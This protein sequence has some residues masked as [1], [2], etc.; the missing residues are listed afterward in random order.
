VIVLAVPSRVFGE[1]VR[2]LPGNAPVVT[3]TKGL[4]PDT[5]GRLCTLVQER[6]V[7]VLSRPN[8][9]EEIAAGLPTASVIASED[10]ELAEPLQA[11]INS[12]TFRVFV[13]PDLLGVELCAATK[14]VIA[15]SAG[16]VDG[17]G[18][19]DNAKAALITRGLVEMARLGQ[20]AG[21]APDTFAGLGGHGRP[22]RHL[23]ASVRPEPTRG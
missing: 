18:L 16:G 6:A 5:G 19:G 15:L 10:A 12:T 2:G 7:A 20:A 13:N 9:A 14:N 21:A 11:E 17:M 22:D 3:L 1:V 4:D 8:T 23:L